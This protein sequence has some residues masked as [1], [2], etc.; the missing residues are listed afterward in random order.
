MIIN[1]ACTPDMTYYPFDKQTCVLTVSAL[2]R[3][4]SVLNLVALT[5]EWNI[6]Y[7]EKSGLWEVRET[8]T[9]TY[10]D[11]I[12]GLYKTDF[13]ITVKR[14]PLFLAL[15]IVLPVLL[16]SMLTGFVFLLPPGSGSRV[17]FGITC[18]LSFVVLLQLVMN[19][20]PE[21]SAPMPLLCFYIVGMLVF[22]VLLSITNVFVLKMYLNSSKN[23]VP[24]W[25]LFSVQTITCTILW[26]CSKH[27][28]PKRCQPIPENITRQ[29]T[30]HNIRF[31]GRNKNDSEMFKND[32]DDEATQE[33]DNNHIPVFDKEC[34]VF[35]E[36]DKQSTVITEFP[37]DVNIKKELGEERSDLPEVDQE[38]YIEFT[39]VDA[40]SRDLRAMNKECRDFPEEFKESVK[41]DKYVSE[42]AELIGKGNNILDLHKESRKFPEVIK[43]GSA[44]PTNVIESSEIVEF[45]QDDSVLSEICN[46]IE[47]SRGYPAAVKE[48][49]VITDLTKDGNGLSELA[50]EQRELSEV[51]EYSSN[52]LESAKEI[53]EFPEVDK[54]SSELEED[55][56]VISE[57]DNTCNSI[58][59]W[60]KNETYSLTRYSRSEQKKHKSHKTLTVL[61]IPKHL[62]RTTSVVINS[63][64][65]DQDDNKI[66]PVEQ[67][68]STLQKRFALCS[69]EE[70]TTK[71]IITQR[72]QL[73]TTQSK[74]DITWEY[75]AHILDIFFLVIF[76][77]VQ[78]IFTVA[79]L[80]PFAA[81]H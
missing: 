73:S 12:T 13:K 51:D 3:D 25:L 68:S 69:V 71:D 42:I 81:Q 76:S 80:A 49:S 56:R 58:P 75:I 52:P 37:E 48:A 32:K 19:V 16:L 54:I 11:T 74:N 20:I 15:V 23:E 41:V 67:P 30:V 17:G 31:T 5:D 57:L 64:Q 44:I 14:K 70:K 34:E 1:A 21:V 77:A 60:V 53:M 4:N 35:P 55:D 27:P 33:M 46:E 40:F 7:L 62:N 61:E 28:K 59:G 29:D 43:V 24:P 72:R 10:A 22:S 63:T 18:F 8:S 36:L 50:K 47:D 78:I 9:V 39:R 26:R 45:K 65:F 38:G 6:L 2:P 79:F 66:T